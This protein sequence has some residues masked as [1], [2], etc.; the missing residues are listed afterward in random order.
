MLYDRVIGN[1]K[2]RHKRIQHM[3]SILNAMR[4]RK[5]KIFSKIHFQGPKSWVACPT[6]R[7]LGLGSRVPPMSWI[8]GLGFFLQGHGSHD[9][10]IRWVLDLGFQAPLFK[11]AI[12]MFRFFL[13]LFI[14]TSSFEINCIE[15]Q[16]M[17][18]VQNLF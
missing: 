13:L 15:I 8:P 17:S 16:T 7:I 10:P 9:P 4:Q 18:L 2:N 14:L 12:S 11:Y 6:F 1:I 5:L 3:N